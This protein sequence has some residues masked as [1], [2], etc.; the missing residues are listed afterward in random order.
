[1]CI[2][3]KYK[4]LLLSSFEIVGLLLFF[5]GACV[6]HDVYLTVISFMFGSSDIWLNLALV[7]LGVECVVISI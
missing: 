4:H 1:M 2:V 6:N 5:C 3:C 7:E